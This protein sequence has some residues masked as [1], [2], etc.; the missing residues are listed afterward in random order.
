MYSTS[1][2]TRED[3]G[4]S[5]LNAVPILA[6]PTLEH[7]EDARVPSGFV[8][9][10]PSDVIDGM[11]QET[12]G[13]TLAEEVQTDGD[14]S[15]TIVSSNNDEAMVAVVIN[16]N[17]TTMDI[18][19]TNDDEAL[20]EHDANVHVT[21]V[22]ANMLS[23][24]SLPTDIYTVL[25][26]QSDEQS[27]TSALRM[28]PVPRKHS[29]KE[30]YDAND[31]RHFLDI[32][33]DISNDDEGDDSEDAGLDEFINNTISESDEGA[34]LPMLHSTDLTHVDEVDPWNDGSEDE[35]G[36]EE[37]LLE[38]Y[39]KPAVA[40]HNAMMQL[41]STDEANQA[42]QFYLEEERCR[43]ER[44]ALDRERY[45][46][47]RHWYPDAVPDT[48]PQ[49][50][51]PDSIVPLLPRPSVEKHLWH[52]T[53]K[54]MGGSY[55]IKSVIGHVSCPDWIY[56]KAKD[57]ID[58]QKLY[59][60]VVYIHIRKIFQV[61]H[62]QAHS[63]L[64]ETPFS[65]AKAGDWVRLTEPKLYSGNLG[66]VLKVMRGL[67]LNMAV[68]PRVIFLPPPCKRNAK[69]KEKA[70]DKPTKQPRPPQC[71]LDMQALFDLSEP[72]VVDTHTW[73]HGPD[74]NGLDSVAVPA[75]WSSGLSNIPKILKKTCPWT[76][77]R[78]HQAWVRPW[79]HPS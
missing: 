53:V 75:H 42:W 77:G 43:A 59:D 18:A 55:K 31:P 2:D 16:S 71:L 68:V 10:T 15:D 24:L 8:N 36:S 78:V 32:E 52:V 21:K 38:P 19:P 17:T 40:S 3:G 65:Y 23:S 73:V 22:H 34:P 49:D 61:S 1:N 26:L 11:M 48:V 54:A 70:E 46:D 79:T 39:D 56:I 67:S 76:F 29:R 37:E 64:V 12:G 44:E 50:L 30:Q 5:V 7:K 60:K 45:P 66:W 6:E 4:S 14:L 47:D 62:E 33:A 57:L 58:V 13:E 25:L 51:I 41:M 35:W 20:T 9:P 28:S 72:Q 27:P 69:G 63:V 74:A